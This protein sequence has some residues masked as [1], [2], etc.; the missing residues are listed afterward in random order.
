VE[1]VNR[2]A[3]S[4]T[5]PTGELSLRK[6]LGAALLRSPELA[7]FAWSVRQAEASQLQASLPPNPELETEFEN[8][9]GTGEFRGTRALETTVLLSQLVELGGKRAKR[10]RLASLDSR[11]AG[12]NYETKRLKVLTDVTRKYAAFLA[13]Q[14]RLGLAQENLKLAATVLEA[15]EKRVSAG[16]SAPTE[17]LKT[18]VEVATSRIETHRAERKLAVAR[19]Q[20]AATWGSEKALFDRA[21]G[22][23]AAIVQPPAIDALGPLLAQNPAIARWDTEAAR[24]QAALHVAMAGAVPNV[25]VGVGYRQSWETGAND[26]AMLV[27][28]SVPL[29]LFDRNQGEISRARFS[30]LKARADRHAAQV[31][32]QTQLMEVYQRLSSAYE[33]SRSLQDEVLPIARKAY[34]AAER[35]F[36]EGK[37]DY[38]DMLDAQRTL[39]DAQSKHVEAL[40]EYHQAATA[41]EGLIG[42]SLSSVG[43]QKSDQK[44]KTNEQ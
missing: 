34:E 17:K 15:V 39:V 32:L 26:R 42:Q 7:S 3:S 10:M 11:L 16:K 13:A 27:T 24:R 19:Q 21:V 12:W 18:S 14:R 36:K 40:A 43:G 28:A 2:A 25:T 33:E 8:F 37:S 22:D 9:A 29:P 5:E 35:S 30:V 31:K 1:S 23:L 6:A 20:L 41:V 44:G 4:E 38:L